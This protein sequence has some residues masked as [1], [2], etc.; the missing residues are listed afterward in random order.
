LEKEKTVDKEELS[1]KLRRV[2]RDYRMEYNGMNKG[3]ESGLIQKE[4]I[5]WKEWTMNG[6]KTW[7]SSISG[8]N[9]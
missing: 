7:G 2:I 1:E 9:K 5:F 8:N 6:K 3:K 4:Y